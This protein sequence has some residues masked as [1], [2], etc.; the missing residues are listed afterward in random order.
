MLKSILEI[1]VLNTVA[2]L[3]ACVCFG[4]LLQRL[5]L[6]V[7]C[8]LIVQYVFVCISSLYGFIYM[9]AVAARGSHVD[10]REMQEY[11]L[12]MFA[13]LLVVSVQMSSMA[14]VHL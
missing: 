9:K 7:L 2:V 11:N 4:L 13:C 10:T 5:D 8:L 14:C 3:V 6:G 12:W 1:C